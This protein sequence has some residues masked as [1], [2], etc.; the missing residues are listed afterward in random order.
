MRKFKKALAFALAS[1][2]IVSAVPASAAAKT[3]SAKGTKSTIYT[4]TVDKS[5]KG[6]ANNKRS[7]IKVTAKKG[8]TY[9]L[10]NKTKNLVSLTKTRVEAKKTGTAK[11]NVNFY[12]NGKYVETKSVKITVKK[13]PMIGKV[14]LSKDTVNVG[15]TATVSNAGKGTAYFYSSNKDVATVDKKTGEIKALAGGTTTISAVNTI[16]KARV[17]L[18]LTVVADAPVAKQAGAKV[19]EVTNGV[20]MKDKKV[21]LK[22]GN[23]EVTLADKDGVKFTEDGKGI[24]ITTAAKLTDNE[25]TVVI[26]DKE[27]KVNAKAEKVAAIKILSDKAA[28]E[29]TASGSSVKYTKAKVGYRVENQFGEDITKQTSLQ[30]NGSAKATL[31]PSKNVIEFESTN[32][33]GFIVNRDVISVVLVHTE[34]ATTAQATLTVSSESAVNSIEYAGIYNADNKALTEDSDLEADTYYMLFN[35]KDQYGYDFDSLTESKQV[36]LSVAGAFTN[37][38]IDGKQNFKKITKDGKTYWGYPLKTLDGKTLS[39]GTATVTAISAGTGVNTTQNIDVAVG[40]KVANLAITVPSTV[41]AG[42]ETTFEYS[43]TDAAG[44]AVTSYKALKDVTITGSSSDVTLKFKEDAKTGNAKLVLDATNHDVTGSNRYEL[45]T[46]T[47]KYGSE[48]KPVINTLQV[49]LKET[50]RPVSIVGL[51]DV[52]T[53]LAAVTGTSGSSITLKV[54]NFKVED[55]YG[56]VMSS[57]VLKK[58]LSKSNEYDLKK[59]TVSG[60]QADSLTYTAKN[61]ELTSLDSEVATISVNK[62]TSSDSLTLNFTIENGKEALT[63]STFTQEFTTVKLDNIE[64]VTVDVNKIYVPKTEGQESAYAMD[65]TVKAKGA[66]L[67]GTQYAVSSNDVKV[68]DGTTSA[69]WKVYAPKAQSE[70]KEF[71]TS[72]E[73]KANITITLNNGTSITKEVILSK[74]APTVKDVTV[75]NTDVKVSSG[76]AIGIKELLEKANV[77]TLKDSYGVAVNKAD[78]ANLKFADGTDVN[79]VVTFKANDG[80]SITNI[81]TKNGTKDAQITLE[82]GKSVSATIKFATGVELVLGVTAE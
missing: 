41:V 46:F 65:V 16:T 54:K 12:K 66:T 64:N 73:V 36:Y 76:T 22:R 27:I 4:Y 50:A 17:Y 2:M 49:Q 39:Q 79:A 19:I 82:N 38:T 10:V 61:A 81:V 25:Y 47:V 56:R 23:T 40:K 26:G 29:N 52:D 5:K 77:T 28:V 6:N 68:Q 24:T 20:S 43:A 18:T 62:T 45:Q 55:Q 3:N 53:K 30:V 33:D 48:M 7:W 42:E 8:Y 74:E 1:A 58:A 13:A 15:E 75:T 31:Q 69:S 21:T 32:A 35:I 9:K 78:L 14:T 80:S 51:K 63:G 70:Y 71:E 59:I 60:D 72:N 37:L 34:T 57:T 44:N 67:P 11:I